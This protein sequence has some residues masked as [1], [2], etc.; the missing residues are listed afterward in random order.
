MHKISI[1]TH[2]IL[3]SE[4]VVSV[5]CIIYIERQMCVWNKTSNFKGDAEYLKIIHQNWLTVVGVCMIVGDANVCPADP[6]G[7]VR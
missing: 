4:I 1:Y 5:L 2:I 6:Q 7:W 3:K